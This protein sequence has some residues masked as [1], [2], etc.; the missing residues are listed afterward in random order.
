M[1]IFL[2]LLLFL[3]SVSFAQECCFKDPG[4]CS[5]ITSYSEKE[6]CRAISNSVILDA[7]CRES[8]ECHISPEPIGKFGGANAQEA[9]SL[10]PVTKPGKSRKQSGE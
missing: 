4:V 6:A 3:P 10:L 5:D 7:T 1:K 8:P 2:F 9:A